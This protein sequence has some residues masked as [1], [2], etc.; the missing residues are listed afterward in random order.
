[1][2]YVLA[3]VPPRAS[4]ARARH[5]AHAGAS[6]VACVVRVICASD[7]HASAQAQPTWFACPP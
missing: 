2:A 3:A 6:P 5:R 7:P 4:C 1:L